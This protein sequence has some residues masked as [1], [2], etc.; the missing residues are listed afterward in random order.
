MPAGGC[1]G[2]QSHDLAEKPPTT[3]QP[4]VLGSFGVTSDR[5]HHLL[6][7]GSLL[8]STQQ[9]VAV[10]PPVLAA[11]RSHCPVCLLVARS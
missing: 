8:P 2:L 11:S 10:S 4:P 1:V 5:E 6:V 7:S 3:R 9:G